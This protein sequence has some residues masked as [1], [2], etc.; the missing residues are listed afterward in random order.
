M[1]S[2]NSRSEY[3]MDSRPKASGAFQ[4]QRFESRATG[5]AASG[6]GGTS[7]AGTSLLLVDVGRG[8]KIAILAV[9]WGFPTRPQ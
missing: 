8:A 3:D 1:K 6:K 5:P 9:Q 2:R 4:Q 7:I